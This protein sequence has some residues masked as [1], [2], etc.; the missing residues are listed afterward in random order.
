MF[1]NYRLR[2]RE[3][4]TFPWLLG[5]K[6]RLKKLWGYLFI[7]TRVVIGKGSWYGII[8]RT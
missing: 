4:G 7:D 3:A 2:Q 1:Q 8:S 6:K 5:G